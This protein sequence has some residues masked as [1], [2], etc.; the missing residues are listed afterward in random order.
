MRKG[1]VAPAAWSDVDDA[2][3]PELLGAGE[4]TEPPPQRGCC[5]RTRVLGGGDGVDEGRMTQLAAAC[6]LLAAAGRDG[7]LSSQQADGDQPR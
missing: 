7:Q 4:V 6:E 5:G 2:M 1:M 3:A